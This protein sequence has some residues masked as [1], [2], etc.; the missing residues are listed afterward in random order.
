MT[1]RAPSTVGAEADPLSADAHKPPA[2][3][4]LVPLTGAC[5]PPIWVAKVTP[6]GKETHIRAVY[7]QC[8]SVLR[9]SIT[10]SHGIFAELC[11]DQWIVPQALGRTLIDMA[12]A[13]S[14][15][16]DQLA[17]VCGPAYLLLGVEGHRG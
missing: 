15:E 6:Q 2:S 4:P 8:N 7:E 3:K 13:S 10:L 16:I 17:R 11:D 9:V 14:D 12:V 5:G 1:G